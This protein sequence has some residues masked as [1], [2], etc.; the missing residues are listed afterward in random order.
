MTVYTNGKQYL[1]DWYNE[2][3]LPNADTG[4]DLSFAE[5]QERKKKIE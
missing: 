5:K 3:K 1:S 4:I 2:C